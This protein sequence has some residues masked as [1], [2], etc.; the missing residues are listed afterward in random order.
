MSC[1]SNIWTSSSKRQGK[2]TNWHCH[3]YLHIFS[4]KRQLNEN[5]FVYRS[6]WLSFHPN[7]TSR[8]FA[9]QFLSS[10][11]SLALSPSLS[12]WWLQRILD[13]E[14]MESEC[15]FTTLHQILSNLT[16]SMLHGCQVYKLFNSKLPSF[17]FSSFHY[18]NHLF[19]S[20]TTRVLV[21]HLQINTILCFVCFPHAA[22]CPVQTWFSL[23]NKC[24]TIT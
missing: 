13:P 5:N 7:R 9:S 11:L 18:T 1:Q 22:F 10:R 2:T 17:P 4:M 23:E 6:W 16:S 8:A 15:L 12:S 24:F 20:E 19:L 21:I 14:F 3:C